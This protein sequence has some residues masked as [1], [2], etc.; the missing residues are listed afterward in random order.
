MTRK[1]LMA[2]L[3]ALTLTGSMMT[4]AFAEIF[5]R[6]LTL[7]QGAGQFTVSDLGVGDTLVLRLVNPTNRAL[8]FE[9]TQNLGNQKSWL[10][11]ANSTATVEFVYT[12][13]FDDDVEFVVR[14]PAQTGVEIAH[15]T[16]MRGGSN[17]STQGTTQQQTT[18]SSTFSQTEIERPVAEQ[19]PM[20]MEHVQPATGS[21]VNIRG[22]W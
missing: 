4:A 19:Q 8:T 3:L 17:I 10:V 2:S 13:P 22:Y 20:Q 5:Q 11:P 1:T 7:D 21:G 16:F 14:D 18:T 15:G 12:R 9:T 6:S